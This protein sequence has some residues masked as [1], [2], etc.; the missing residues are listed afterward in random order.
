MS[1]IDLDGIK[2]VVLDAGGVLLLPDP[3]NMRAAFGPLGVEPDDETCRRAHYASMREVDRLGR[4][5]WPAVDRVLAGIAGVPDDRVEEAIPLIDE[6][7]LRLPW[8]PCHG[9]AET[10]RSLQEAGYQLAV[11]SNASGTMEQQLLEHRICS[12]EGGEEADVAIVVDSHV[13]GVEKPDPRIFDYA[14][15]AL[16]LEA[17]R[18]I[19]VG[20]TV[21]FDVNGARAAGLHPVHVDPYELCP[22]RDHDHIAELAELTLSLSR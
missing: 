16:G 6:I 13:V 2:A 15:D 11:V 14:L 5:D 22:D 17:E 10:L 20:D 3:A 1:G 12:V 9:A 18:C 21:H 4:P 19:Y 7:Y 8:V